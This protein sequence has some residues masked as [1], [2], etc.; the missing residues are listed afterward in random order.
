MNEIS[1]GATETGVRGP[2]PGRGWRLESN[3]E[4][5]QYYNILVNN[6][7][8]LMLNI[9]NCFTVKFLNLKALVPGNA[10]KPISAQDR[11]RST[12]LQQYGW[13]EKKVFFVNPTIWTIPMVSPLVQTSAKGSGN[14]IMPKASTGRTPTAISFLFVM[15]TLFS[16]LLPFYTCM[17]KTEKTKLISNVFIAMEKD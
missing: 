12:A 8:Y 1:T 14:V 5:A 17:A 11:L 13:N 3:F 16:V 15:F 6:T 7:K 9:S 10:G 4:L 2:V